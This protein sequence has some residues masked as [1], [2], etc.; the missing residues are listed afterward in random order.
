MLGLIYLHI[1][2]F[3]YNIFSMIIIYFKSLF[4]RLSFDIIFAVKWIYTSQS[5]GRLKSKGFSYAADAMSTNC[6]CYKKLRLA[7]VMAAA[8]ATT[9]AATMV[10]VAII[11]A[12]IQW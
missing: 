11:L 9:L 12:A 8:A 6:K 2:L 7:A 5:Y 1:I 4:Y 3:I 10:A